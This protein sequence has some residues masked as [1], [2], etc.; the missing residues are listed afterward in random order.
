MRLNKSPRCSKN[1]RLSLA[2]F[3]LA[4]L[5]SLP[6]V[7]HF[8]VLYTPQSALQRPADIPFTLVFTHVY[9]GSPTMDMEKPRR[10]FYSRRQQY[11]TPSSEVDL[12]QFLEPIEWQTE[13]GTASAWEAVIPRDTMR[14]LGDYQV[15]VE[16]E[17]Y[18]DETD[19][20]YIQQFT[21]VM[22]NVGGV[23]GNWAETIGLPAEIQALN[24]PYA[25][26]AGG[27]F[28]GVVVSE[29]IPVPFTQVEVNYL[30]HP[31]E[32][33]NRRF[34]EEP[35]YQAPH[36]AF[37]SMIILTNEFGEFSFSM[38]KAG[39]WGFSALGVGP[40][41]EFDGEPLSQDAILWVQATDF[42]D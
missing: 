8:T 1:F 28:R 11:G 38:P 21:K 26:W 3:C 17:P 13:D 34:R 6:A 35:A 32:R 20:L 19:E 29:G 4:G 24:K 23:P 25:N 30:N 2:G 36:P 39:W 42:P 10:F 16:S 12:S 7:A 18:Y 27:V 40:E 5:F 14:S 9:E 33:D 15:V 22:V 37:E 41:R 31:P